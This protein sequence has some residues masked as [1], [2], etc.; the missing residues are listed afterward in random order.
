MKNP[1]TQL[2]DSDSTLAIVIKLFIP[3]AL[4]FF[5]LYGAVNLVSWFR[6]SYSI[7]EVTV[8]GRV[9]QPTVSGPT[10]LKDVE[11]S[12]VNQGERIY[13]L[14][15]EK[16]AYTLEFASESNIPYSKRVV[17]RYSQYETVGQEVTITPNMSVLEEVNLSISPL[18]VSLEEKQ[19]LLSMVKE[20]QLLLVDQ[21]EGFKDLADSLVKSNIP[22][23][24]LNELQDIIR[25]FDTNIQWLQDDRLLFDK[26]MISLDRMKNVLEETTTKQNALIASKD[27]LLL[28]IKNYSLNE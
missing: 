23:S 25:Q 14:T 17:A 24:V 20:L 12:I 9:Y 11:V 15:D 10:P 13:T 2:R 5:V 1:F 6:N 21:S 8:S 27:K 3:I 18:R 16:G 4:V 22:Q 7:N 26:N 28:D 19:T